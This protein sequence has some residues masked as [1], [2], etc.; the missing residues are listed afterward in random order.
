[1]I[2]D[3]VPIY[4]A[5]L[6]LYN[7][8]RCVYYRFSVL[9]VHILKHY[10]SITEPLKVKITEHNILSFIRIAIPEYTGCEQGRPGLPY[11]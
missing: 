3:C 6:K 4:I 8:S 1:M 9:V 10:S 5:V 2:I 7:N 11:T